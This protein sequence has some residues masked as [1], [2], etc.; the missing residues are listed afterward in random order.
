[1]RMVLRN[2]F[3]LDPK[4]VDIHL[5]SFLIFGSTLFYKM[6]RFTKIA[7]FLRR[8]GIRLVVYL[9]DMLIMN[10]S[11]DRTKVDVD[12]VVELLQSLGFLINWEKSIVEPSQIIEYL[13]LVIDSVRLSFSLP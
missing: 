12:T 9:D 11:K 4:G 10:L 1:M 2:T 6:H 3:R 8:Q 5:F 7:A 13:G